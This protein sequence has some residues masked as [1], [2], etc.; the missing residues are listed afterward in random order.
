M[1]FIWNGDSVDEDAGWRMVANAFTV[2]KFIL[3]GFYLQI[4]IRQR[5]RKISWIIKLLRFFEAMLVQHVTKKNL[6]VKP[7]TTKLY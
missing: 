1:L 3:N 5:K 7:Q 4:P 6:W 2:N